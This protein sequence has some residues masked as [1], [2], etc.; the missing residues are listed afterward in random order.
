[1]STYSFSKIKVRKLDATHASEIVVM[2][3]KL[4]HNAV[5]ISG[6]VL[7]KDDHNICS[8]EYLYQYRFMYTL[9]I[10][11]GDFFFVFPKSSFHK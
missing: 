3:I 10:Y 11:D 5:V 9:C 7:A 1:M 4:M 2:K 6:S 8:R